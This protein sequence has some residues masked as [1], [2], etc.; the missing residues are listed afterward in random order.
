MSEE[1]LTNSDGGNSLN[2]ISMENINAAADDGIHTTFPNYDEFQ[3]EKSS[4]LTDFQ[5]I[6]PPLTH[7][8]NLDYDKIGPNLGM[9]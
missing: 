2:Q 5:S 8:E 3:P 7:F 6:V 1:N 9:W 4:A